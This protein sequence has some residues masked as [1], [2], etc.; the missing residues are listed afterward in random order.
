MAVLIRPARVG[1]GGAILTVHRRAIHEIACADYPREILAAWGTPVPE[2]ELAQQGDVFDEKVKRGEIVLVAEVN[3][4]IAG[5]GE[6]IPAKCEL[7]AVYEGVKGSRNLF[8]KSISRFLAPRYLG[9]LPKTPHPIRLHPNVATD[10]RDA[11]CQCLGHQQA[12]KRV[13]VVKR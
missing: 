7:L 8:T 1:E 4:S 12:V 9:D 11:L 2:G 10:E 3:G 13:A 5:F 6:I